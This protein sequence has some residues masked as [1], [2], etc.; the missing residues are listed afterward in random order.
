MAAAFPT[1]ASD[2]GARIMDWADALAVHTEQ[3]GMLTRTY[4]TEAHHGAAA[5]LT[6]WMQDAGMTVRRYAAGNVIGRYE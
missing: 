1:S 2:V 5:Q 4:L 6:A 3:P